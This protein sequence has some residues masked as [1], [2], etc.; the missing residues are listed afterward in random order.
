MLQTLRFFLQNGAYFIMLPFWVSV[1]FT[2]YTQRVLKF[3][4]KFPVPK[5]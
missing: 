1:L 4:Y 3:K 5:V 2:F